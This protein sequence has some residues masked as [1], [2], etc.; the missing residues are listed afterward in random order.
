MATAQGILAWAS[1]EL[2]LAQELH[3]KTGLDHLA[4]RLEKAIGLGVEA[5]LFGVISLSVMEFLEVADPFYLN[6]HH[7]YSRKRKPSLGR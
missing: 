2:A 5:G 4:H 1:E 3:Q 7:H 6:V